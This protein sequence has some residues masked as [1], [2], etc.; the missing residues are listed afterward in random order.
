MFSGM[1]HCGNSLGHVVTKFQ[2]TE[3][4]FLVNIG[5]NLQKIINK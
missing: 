3:C 1:F 4:T 5:S 2:L